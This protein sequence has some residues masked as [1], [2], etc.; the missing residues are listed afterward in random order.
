MWWSVLLTYIRFYH[1]LKHIKLDRNTLA[2]WAP[3]QPWLSYF[4]FTMTSLM[5]IFNCSD[6]VLNPESSSVGDFILIYLPLPT[7]ALL[8]I[9]WKIFHK[10]NFVRV[11]QMDFNKEISGSNQMDTVE[12][13]DEA[14]PVGKFKKF[15]NWLM[16]KN[17]TIAAPEGGRS[18]SK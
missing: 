5:I 13:E 7:F 15:L 3:F 18:I 12:K 11:D 9:G 14:R 4:G 16:Q 8:F 17:E 6:L 10:T 1:G 2:Y